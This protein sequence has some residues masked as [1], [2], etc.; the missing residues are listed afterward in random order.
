MFLIL[1]KRFAPGSI[2]MNSANMN[3]PVLFLVFNRP[4]V[5]TRVFEAIR[6]AQPP[7]LYIAADGAREQKDGEATLCRRVR[8]IVTAV[9]WPCEVKTLFRDTNLGCKKAVSEGVTWF[10]ENEAMGI[11][12]ED[13]CLPEH[14][15]F[16]FCEEL[17]F[18]YEHD[19]RIMMICGTNFANTD[20]LESAYYFTS[21]PRIWGWASWRRVWN[22]YDVNI[23]TFPVVQKKQLFLNRFASENEYNY[24]M[25]A[26]T[27]V[28]LG[29]I[30]TWD[31]Q[32][33][34]NAFTHSRLSI[35]PRRNLISNIGFGLD[36]THTNETNR[37]AALPV[38]PADEYLT[39][40]DMVMPLLS[41]ESDIK[42]LEGIEV[43]YF[44]FL[45]RQIKQKLVYRK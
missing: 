31:I 40:P 2:I 27:R 35:C 43:T 39:P 8:E 44:R 33:S 28:S 11:I 41:A 23:S 24:W 1:F 36:A 38:F 9:D 34:Y 7:K 20:N 15:F 13:D 16:R 10:F 6:A 21:Y 29:E 12:L 5:T 42:K 22:E 37:L 45:L 25:N 17:L 30:D 4:D 32:V 18:R 14:S 19:Q 26:F 3:L